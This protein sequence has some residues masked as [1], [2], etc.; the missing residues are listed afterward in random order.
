MGGLTAM[1]GAHLVEPLL[2]HLLP[3]WGVVLLQV[4]DEAQQ[5]TLC[6]VAHLLC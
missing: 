6:L 4:Q 2:W 3:D 1:G 5:T